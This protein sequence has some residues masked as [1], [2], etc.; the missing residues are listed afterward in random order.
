MSEIE[1]VAIYLLQTFGGLAVCL[2]AL[3][4]GGSP[5]RLGAGLIVVIVVL[6]RT[7]AAFMAPSAFP[8]IQLVCDALIGVGLLAVALAYGSLWIGG[9]M[10]LYA[11][12]FT[13]H[14]YYFVTERPNDLFHAIVNNLIFIGVL[15]C[16]ALGTVISWVQR[17]RAAKRAAVAA[18]AA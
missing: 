14:S 8:V 10:L 9:A 1:S 7:I 4:K 6:Q 13:L 3:W 16:L 18:P 5:E 15:L 17:A 2:F 11:A 12:Q